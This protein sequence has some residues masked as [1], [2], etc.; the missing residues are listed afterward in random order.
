MITIKQIQ[1]TDC[2]QIR[3]QVL[4]Q[5]KNIEHCGIDIDE[6]E[7]AFHLGGFLNDKLVC[8]GSFFK[9]TNTQFSEKN[10]YRLRAMATLAYAQ[11]QG[12]AKALLDFAFEK[13]LD[14]NQEIIWCDA[15]LVAIGFYEK[16]GFTKQGEMYEI[17]LI[18]YHYLMWKSVKRKKS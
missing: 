7:G 18:G 2:Y 1:A 11:K 10:Q 14:L 5:H 8:I 15:R 9:Q 17:P 16:I 6:Q 12:A 3:Q 13:L 4:W